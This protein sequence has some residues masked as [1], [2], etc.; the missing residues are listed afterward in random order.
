VTEWIAF[1]AA[2]VPAIGLIFAGQQFMLG[3]RQAREDRLLGLKG[4]VAYWRPL[5]APAAPGSGGTAVWKY[6]ITVANPGRFPIDHVKVAWTF[7]CPVERVRSNGGFDEPTFVIPLGLPV[8]PG[9]GE[10][11]WDRT[12]RIDFAQATELLPAT[13]AEVTF[14]DIGGT[15]RAN[16]WPRKL[17]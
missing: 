8:L 13:Y 14:H 1:A 11:T 9:G 15:V 6:K 17:R 7:A 10:H 2:I 5:S 3:N 12:L 4:V 16:R